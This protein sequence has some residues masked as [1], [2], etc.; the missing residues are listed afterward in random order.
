MKIKKIAAVLLIT[1][2]MIGLSRSALADHD[3]CQAEIAIVAAEIGWADFTNEMDRSRLSS[4]AEAASMKL[5][6]H[7]PYDAIGKLEDIAY[8]VEALAW[9]GRKAKL[10]Q[11]D[12]TTILGEVDAA[13]TC[14]NVNMSSFY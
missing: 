4:K 8:K 7:K 6:V 10:D 11:G 2:P 9:G 1:L 5:E 14:I 13:I 3:T 12:A